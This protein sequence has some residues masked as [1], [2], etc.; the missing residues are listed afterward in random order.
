M[1][2]GVGLIVA[3]KPLDPALEREDPEATLRGCD[4]LA[5]HV[6]IVRTYGMPAVVAINA[7]PGDHAS[8]VEVVRQAALD[9]GAS[10]AVVSRHFIDGGA[11][12]AELA[13]AVWTAAKVGA[14]DF[15]FLVPPE[16]TLTQRIEAIATL[17]YGADGVDIAPEARKQLHEFGRLGYGSLPI[18][19]AK[20]QLSLS[21][22]P[23]LKGRPRGFRVPIRDARLF[24][25]A[26]FVTA[27]CG[28]MR[29][30]PGLP[31]RP[32]GEAVDIDEKGDIVGLF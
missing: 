1:H 12:A 25:G 21:H 29:T 4:N 8:E 24:A 2:G 5:Q 10:D 16:A 6:A 19:M 20:T 30:M 9:A 7:F 11:G 22:D 31:S 23:A 27:Y 26:G 15:R 3:G 32:A 17:I 13:R 28:D 18:C 14:P